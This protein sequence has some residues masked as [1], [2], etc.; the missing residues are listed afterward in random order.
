MIGKRNDCYSGVYINFT[1]R[2]SRGLV[3]VLLLL[4]LVA[5]LKNHRRRDGQVFDIRRQNCEYG[6]F[7]YRHSTI[8]I[9]TLLYPFI[10]YYTIPSKS[11]YAR[12]DVGME[13]GMDVMMDSFLVQKLNNLKLKFNLS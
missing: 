8:P 10:L 3:A 13:V 1:Q 6:A 5:T 2:G 12:M 11:S 9:D 7:Y 4:L